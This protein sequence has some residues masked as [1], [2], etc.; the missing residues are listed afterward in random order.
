MT[1]GLGSYT[2][3][4]H[5]GQHYLSFAVGSFTLTRYTH[6]NPL[7]HRFTS[8]K[9]KTTVFGEN[10]IN[11][12]KGPHPSWRFGKP[13]QSEAQWT[14]LVILRF[15]HWLPSPIDPWF[16]RPSNRLIHCQKKHNER[17]QT[18][19]PI[20]P[21]DLPW[22]HKSAWSIGP[23]CFHHSLK[24]SVSVSSHVILLA[25]VETCCKCNKSLQCAGLDDERVPF[26]YLTKSPEL[27]LD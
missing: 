23:D 27:S 22:S 19:K 4:W 14:L 21:S 17:F 2:N 5:H 24:H 8:C 20:L 25:S 18:Q 9:L 11:I 3:Q 10:A 1:E 15:I 16:H 26:M 7:A 6:T 13:L 12:L